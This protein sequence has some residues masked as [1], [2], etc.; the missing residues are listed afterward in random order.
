MIPNPTILV[1]CTHNDACMIALEVKGEIY[2]CTVPVDL[3]TTHASAL[4]PAIQALWVQQ[5]K[6]DP[7]VIITPRGPGSFTSV[8]ICLTVAQGFSLA[9]PKAQIFTPTNFSL[10]K[11]LARKTDAITLIDSKRNT[12]FACKWENS[13][14][15]EP[16]E[17]SKDDIT[18]DESYMTDSPNDKNWAIALIELYHKQKGVQSEDQTLTPYYFATPH[19]K[20]ANSLIC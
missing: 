1:F 4:V 13:L 14:M 15:Q 8:R 17:I 6:L 12:Y 3:K 7:D 11:E 20:K 18:L 5:G 16:Y 10:L 2:E 9:F 19:Y